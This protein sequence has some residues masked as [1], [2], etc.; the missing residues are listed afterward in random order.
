MYALI[1]IRDTIRVPPTKFSGHLDHA[2]LEIVRED[3]EGLVDPDTGVVV[4]IVDA[5]RLGEGKIV[6]G[7]PAAYF[8]SQITFISY[9]PQVNEVVEGN[10]SE[11][12]EFGAFL[13][14]GP[15]EGL[16]HVSQI[17]DDFV[18]FDAKLPGFI[19]RDS[20][21]TLKV[22]D[23]VIARIVSVSMKNSV[24]DSKIGLTMRQPG[25]G[26]KEWAKIKPA[27]VAKPK[28]KAPPKGGD[29]A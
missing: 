3:V 19:G 26:K 25:L 13:R 15:I 8:D 20:K 14:T 23:N 28:G 7:D 4:A 12:T 2:V 16:I 10:I 27:R 9:K 22:G 6:P 24:P 11:A 1:T 17:A 5:K 21:R 18:S 29:V